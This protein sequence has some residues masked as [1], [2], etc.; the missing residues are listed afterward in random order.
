LSAGRQECLPHLGD[1]GQECLPIHLALI[2]SYLKF[3]EEAPT[4]T[5][6]TT[7]Q[8][9]GVKCP[10]KAVAK[11]PPTLPYIGQDSCYYRLRDFTG[12]IRYED[13]AHFLAI[14]GNWAIGKSRLAHELVAQACGQ[15]S[16]WILSNGDQAEP[17]L[18][19]PK[20][21]SVIMP[22]FV[23][24]VEVLYFMDDFGVDIS[25]IMGKIVCAATVNLADAERGRKSYRDLLEGLRGAL[26]E[27][28]PNFDFDHLAFIANDSSYS[29]PERAARISQAFTEMTKGQIT[30]LLVIV[31]EVEAGG[32]TDPFAGER[33]R[34]LSN[35]PISKRAVRDLYEGVKEAANTNA[36]PRLNFVFFNS[37]ASRNEAH[38]EALERRMLKADL[39]KASADDLEQMIAALQRNGYPLEGTLLDLAWRAFFAADRNFGWFSFIMNKAHFALID[40]PR[41]E[42]GQIF[43]EVCKLTGKV[44]QPSTFED[45]DI[46]PL[47][48]KDAMREVIYNQI[49]ATLTDLGIAPELWNALL[50][51]Q[52]PFQ[53]RFAGEA[54]LVDVSADQLTTG[55]MA[56]GLYDSERKPQLTGEGSPNFDPAAVLAS[57][58]TFAWTRDGEPAGAAARLWIYA[59]PAD[60]EGQ[61]SF[62]YPG[63]GA[64]L[65][66]ATVRTMHKLLLERHRVPQT[67]RLIA[68]TMAL[69]RRFNDLWGK[70]AANNWLKEDLW[71]QVITTIDRD[72]GKNDERLL[73]GVA[74]TLFENPTV[75]VNPQ[76]ADVKAPYLT[77]KLESHERLNV[78]SRNQL[79]LLKARE[80]PQAVTDDLRAIRARVPVLLLFTRAQDREIWQNHLKDTHS[81]HLAISVISHLVE[82]QTREWEFYIRYA[83]RDQPGSFKSNEVSQKGRDLQGEFKQI[84]L[85]RFESWLRAAEI[86]GY[87]LRP[88][89]PA[90]S[91]STPTYREFAQAYRKLVVVGGMAALGVEAGS[92]RKALEG[93]E[94]VQSD[95]TMALI[96]GE[97]DRRR[98]L[99]PPV[100]PRILDLLRVKARKPLDLDS[101]LFYARPGGAETFPAGSAGVL[102]QVMALMVEL[103]V[104]ETNQVSEY[105]ARTAS[106]FD[107][108]FDDAF[109]RL[110][111]F[112]TVK[113]GYAKQV[114]ELSAPVQALAGQLRVNHDQL[115]LL[116]NHELTPR[117]D[118][119]RQ[120]PLAELSQF[121]PVNQDAFEQ[122]ARA[123]GEIA[124]AL[125][126]V[127]GK[128]GQNVQPPAIDPQ[129]LQDNINR[130]AGDQSYIEFSI[131]YRVSFLRDLEAYL[132]EAEHDLRERIATRRA[133]VVERYGASQGSAERFPT[134]PMLGLLAA[135]EADLDGALPGN[136]LPVGLSQQAN[137]SPL[138]VLKGANNLSG[139]LLKL[140]WYRRQLE[141]TNPD[142]WWVRY[143]TAYSGWSEA[144]TAYNGVREAWADLERY[145]AGTAEEV[146]NKFTGA[147]LPRDM[148]D[149]E[150]VVKGFIANNDTR[151]TTIED[152]IKESD[153]IRKR[154]ASSHEVIEAARRDAQAE[155]LA[156]LDQPQD[157]AVAKLAARLNN[158]QNAPNSQQVTTARTYAAGRDELKRYAE[159]ILGKG[160]A[161]C[162]NAELFQRYMQ[163]YYDH[164]QG[165]TDEQIV[166][167]YGR[168]V[169]DALSERKLITLRTV[170]EF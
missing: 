103:G 87:V 75:V 111:S 70:A 30:R 78:T 95:R 49:P 69:L 167:R 51:Y 79:V 136:T 146:R 5:T 123:I 154:C 61:V 159:D 23:S 102:E 156:Q 89:F 139:V 19:S 168:Q 116:K 24:L 45:R 126:Q 60:F 114:G 86:Q 57:L 84:L 157:Q 63:F 106:A 42:I 97:G 140:A 118:S 117:K 52:D 135:M 122:V 13:E 65:S 72:P 56:T 151:D 25:T 18:Q 12:S 10:F 55:L 134:Q 7:V 62:A 11:Y 98:A 145:F 85:D 121:P 68:P 90:R 67:A 162:G 149:L 8:L 54:V 108:K 66:A 22:L 152:L 133:E 17:L 130:I 99:I 144:A 150:E 81:E 169:L 74:N 119:L 170:V 58:R 142:G 14:S 110:G 64:N 101:E 3:Q 158:P 109:Q 88:F 129:T 91:A 155:I 105:V 93:Y 1:G 104:V 59:D 73:R 28:D 71:E 131:E 40:N 100:M 53:T 44:F 77:L 120:L 47:T 132:G 50:N 41:L 128:P 115:I 35:R 92:V 39:D 27:L 153:E 165:M 29:Y 33:D 83:L 6:A 112:D 32:E 147:T 21:G 96:A 43:A 34:E 4:V 94:Q 141:D 31:D 36:Y 161:L 138:K 38:L 125:D 160:A 148:A 16:G 9:A 164:R 124:A 2:R 143:N 76:L 20:D 127:L 80:T 15:S 113:S 46:Q 107:A 48:L 37:E 26:C 82:P 166:T 163:I 137:E